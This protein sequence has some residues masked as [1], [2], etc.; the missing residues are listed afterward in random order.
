MKEYAKQLEKQTGNRIQLTF[1]VA[2]N[3]VG[4]Q[5][6]DI[7]DLV[8]A[9]NDVVMMCAIDSKAI[10][11]GIKACQDA[12]VPAV[13][14]VRP[15][16]EDSGARANAFVGVDTVDQGYTTG[17]AVFEK[18]KKDGKLAQAKALNII[19]DL[20]DENAINRSTGF[21]MA[22]KEY[23]VPIVAEIECEWN[24]DLT[25]QRTTAALAEHPEVNIIFC[26]TDAVIQ[27]LQTAMERNNKWFPYGDPRHVYLGS[28]D[29][30]PIGYQL[31]KAGYIDA[32]TIYDPIIVAKKALEF[33][34]AL[35]EGKLDFYGIFV[36]LSKGQPSQAGP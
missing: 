10:A 30:Y 22:C 17:K 33:C 24:N 12:G 6:A 8:N 31:T 21:K 7:M 5:L 25:L 19:G 13:T 23:N 15:E 34:I 35:A 18:M 29:A 26:P 3:D 27:G 16:A 32:D 28:Q 9:G 4:K 1:T 20:R 36:N 2:D 11:S 14:V